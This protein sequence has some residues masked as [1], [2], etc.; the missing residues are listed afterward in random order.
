MVR[1]RIQ[2]IY[3]SSIV[4]FGLSVMCHQVAVLEN[5]FQLQNYLL[6]NSMKKLEKKYIW[7]IFMLFFKDFAL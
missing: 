4:Q 5:V 3:L 7:L 6:F 1:F 2:P